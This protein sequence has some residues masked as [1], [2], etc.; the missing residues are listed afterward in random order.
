VLRRRDA[1]TQRHAEKTLKENEGFSSLRL[2]L[3]LSG[4]VN[5]FV[6]KQVPEINDLPKKNNAGAA[7]P[8]KPIEIPASVR[9]F[10]VKGAVKESLGSPG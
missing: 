2:S 9:W 3:R 1:E 8:A 5:N 6:E 4:E 10:R 7:M